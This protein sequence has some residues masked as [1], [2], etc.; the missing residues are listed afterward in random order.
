MKYEGTLNGLKRFLTD[1]RE[2]YA[3]AK[4]EFQ[5]EGKILRLPSLPFVT[6]RL[7]LPHGKTDSEGWRFIVKDIAYLIPAEEIRRAIKPYEDSI[8]YQASERFYDVWQINPN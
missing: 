7:D 4:I 5:V 8:K 1:P 3:V 6:L 2:H